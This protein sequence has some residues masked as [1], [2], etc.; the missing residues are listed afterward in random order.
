MLLTVPSRRRL[1]EDIRP[2]GASKPIILQ[3]LLVDALVL[4][5]L[6]CAVGLFFG[7]LLSVAAF[8]ATPGYLSSAFPIGNDRIVTFHAVGLAVAAGFAAALGGVLWP[9]RDLFI[10]W[11][12]QDANKQPRPQN[13][14]NVLRLGAG[15]VCLGVTTVILAVHRQSALIGSVA[16]L[17]ALICF[18]P[19]LFDAFARLFD[20]VQGRFFDSVVTDLAVNE[21]RNPRIRVRSLAIA[22]TGA[23]AVFGA[24]SVGGTQVNLEHGL[25]TSAAEIDSA[26]EVWVAPRDQASILTT[27]PFHDISQSLRRVQG[28][29]SVDTYRGSF[30]DWGDRRLWVLAPSANTPRMIPWDELIE[31]DLRLADERLRAGGWVVLSSALASEHH[32]RIGDRFTFPAPR[33]AVYHVAAISTNLGWPPG[34]LI[35]NS[36]DYARAWGSTEPSAYQLQLEPGTSVTYLRRRILEVAPKQTGLAVESVNER[37]HRHFS[38]I[39]QGLSRLTQITLLVLI[40]GALAVAGA[41]GSMLWQRRSLIAFMKVDGYPRAVLWCWLV[42]E[43]ALILAAGC[44]AGAIFGLY[45]QLLNSYA[46]A[47]VTGLPISLSVEAIIAAISFAAVSVIALGIVAVPG[48][49][50]VRVPPS[51]VSP[52]Y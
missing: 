29:R 1:I 26:A 35:L 42:C 7:E 30:L 18:L 45:G 33:P 28:V 22:L 3:I 49:L 13:K 44:L 4:G 34:A 16:L 21:L 17:I 50:V 46:L 12:E 24:V 10:G 25:Q 31:G 2:Q 40:A 48:Y 43:S 8:K 20:A 51:T 19:Y 6:A 9:V 52:A 47:S 39:S 14:R 11:L 27:T 41:I 36:A 15:L 37:Q 23:I 38:L 32:L 5:V